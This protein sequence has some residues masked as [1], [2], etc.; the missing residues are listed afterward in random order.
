M[1]DNV[2]EQ[3]KIEPVT[4]LVILHFKD[5]C[6]YLVLFFNISQSNRTNITDFSQPAISRRQHT[7]LRSIYA[8]KLIRSK[9][10]MAHQPPLTL[11]IDSSRTKC[12]RI[13]QKKGSSNS[14]FSRLNGNS[15]DT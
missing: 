10:S 1:V 2:K 12:H 7:K 3:D 13:V 8:S 4:G 9:D 5:C 15:I 6:A 14:I 11:T